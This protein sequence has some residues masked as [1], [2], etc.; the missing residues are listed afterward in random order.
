MAV[1]LLA[2]SQVEYRKATQRWWENI[3]DS[4][5]V[6]LS[7]R[8]TYF[9]SSNTHS[10]VNMLSGFALRREEELVRFLREY[11]D[12]ESPAKPKG[13]KGKKRR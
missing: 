7:E 13:R 3:D 12:D 6:D 4:I 5:S 10:M 8:P 1:H 2:G 11:A 9:V